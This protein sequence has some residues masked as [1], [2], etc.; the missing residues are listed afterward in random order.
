MSFGKECGAKRAKNLPRCRDELH[1]PDPFTGLPT[2]TA[3]A[4][5]PRRGWH[6]PE[7]GCEGRGGVAGW[8][9]ATHHGEATAVQ[10]SN[11][12]ALTGNGPDGPPSV[13]TMNFG[14]TDTS[15]DFARG[16][17]G[18]EDRDTAG[19]WSFDRD[20]R[21]GQSGVANRALGIL[22]VDSNFTPGT[23]TLK[24]YFDGCAANDSCG[25]RRR[26]SRSETAPHRS[27]A[28]QDSLE[29][30]ERRRSVLEHRLRAVHVQQVE[31]VQLDQLLV[32][33]G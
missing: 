30:Y 6:V 21:S 18:Q 28:A 5:G 24:N 15:G 4:I 19:L 16:D 12:W 11:S 10:D 23:I 14:Q 20:N 25:R 2:I 9:A 32:L 27:F 22:P 3:L 7:H 13:S 8:C 1:P 17:G 33:D 29:H 26:S 31:F